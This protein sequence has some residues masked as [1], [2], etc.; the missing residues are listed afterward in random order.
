DTDELTG[1]SNR[2][3]FNRA[4]AAHLSGAKTSNGPLALLLIDLDGFKAVN[5]RCGHLMGDQ[6][7][8]TIAAALHAPY[9][10]ACFSARLG[11]DE[12]AIL[13]P[14]MD[15]PGVSGL[16]ETLLVDLRHTVDVGDGTLL[17]VSGT[18]GI[19]WFEAGLS[20]R[21][22]LRRADVGL[23]NGKRNHRGT[24]TVYSDAIDR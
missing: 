23:Y 21:E 4:F 7:L 19:S 24:A 11:G 5:D 9:L 12:F 20:E 14:G 1:L 13:A 16:I 15:E 18:I 3:G 2:A 8:Q 6:V 10:A 17:H 22:L